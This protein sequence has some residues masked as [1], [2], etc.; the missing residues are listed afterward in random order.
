MGERGDVYFIEEMYC[1]QRIFVKKAAFWSE[2]L[3]KFC[4][5]LQQGAFRKG[6]RLVK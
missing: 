5:W 2:R 1:W 6:T 4:N 3:K